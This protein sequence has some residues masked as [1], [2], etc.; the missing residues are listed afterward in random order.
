LV[1][2]GNA[3]QG[4]T[5]ESVEAIDS[6]RGIGNIG[7]HMERDINMIVPVD[8]GEAKILIELIEELFSDWYVA[9]HKRKERFDRIKAMSQQKQEF[10][11]AAKA[12]A[13]LLPPEAE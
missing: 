5:I 9:R 1:E 2:A 3:P 6:V 8:S 11:A 13:Q 4:V 10:I 12:P 7:A